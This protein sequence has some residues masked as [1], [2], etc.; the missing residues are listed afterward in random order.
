MGKNERPRY[1]E[2]IKHMIDRQKVFF[3]EKPESITS[4]SPP[5]KLLK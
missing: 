2:M 3:I 1:Q 5:N 4:F